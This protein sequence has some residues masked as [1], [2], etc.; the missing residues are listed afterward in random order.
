MRKKEKTITE[1]ALFRYEFRSYCQSFMFVCLFV[2]SWTVIRKLMNRWF[3]ANTKDIESQT[4][5]M[6]MIEKKTTIEYKRWFFH[7]T[8][9]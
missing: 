7:R 4:N 9:N 2:L 1:S 3:F 6:I 8:V 5:Q